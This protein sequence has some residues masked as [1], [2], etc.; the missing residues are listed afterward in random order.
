ML[1][2]QGARALPPSAHLNLL[3]IPFACARQHRLCAQQS[4]SKDA[5]S[6]AA[7]RDTPQCP[8]TG[9]F[10]NANDFLLAE[11]L[12]LHL[13]SEIKCAGDGFQVI[14]LS[15][16]GWFVCTLVTSPHFEPPHFCKLVMQTAMSC[17]LSVYN[18]WYGHR[19]CL[20]SSC[21]YVSAFV[22]FPG[23]HLA[24][25]LLR[26]ISNISN[27]GQRVVGSQFAILDGL[28][29][30]CTEGITMS[31]KSDSGL[32]HPVFPC[33]LPLC[34]GGCCPDL[35][36]ESCNC[37][38]LYRSVVQELCLFLLTAFP[39]KCN[40]ISFLWSSC[41]VTRCWHRGETIQAI[42]KSMHAD[43]LGWI[44]RIKKDNN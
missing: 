39:M 7:E 30:A 5:A 8:F 13:F 33:L 38:L 11:S 32:C 25:E 12:W 31:D 35:Y 20:I 9:H 2:L 22:F 23:V 21:T 43:F 36:P 3:F 1:S 24:E 4:Q 16:T 15:S 28:H 27:L 42:A 29:P 44:Q 18:P 26:E 14:R 37:L 41:K 34:W 10:L 19:F 40:H 17:C 6:T